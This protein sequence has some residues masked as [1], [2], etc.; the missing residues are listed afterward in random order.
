MREVA[1]NGNVFGDY[2]KVGA[3]SSED[4]TFLNIS[5]FFFS[6]PNMVHLQQSKSCNL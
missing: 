2:P 4:E 3:I 6:F 1:D 5:V